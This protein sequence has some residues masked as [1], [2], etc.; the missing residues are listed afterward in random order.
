MQY[1]SPEVKD[2][3]NLVALTAEA[4]GMAHLGF[5]T[6]AAVS[7][8]IVPGPGGG[9]T[10][11]TTDTGRTLGDGATADDL[12]G[13]GGGGGGGGDGDTAGESG[14]GTD[15][16]GGG[17]GSGGGGAAGKLPFTGFAAAAVGALGAGLAA[18]GAA[19]RKYLS[20][21]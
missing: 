14:S 9:D 18:A 5:G 21:G 12:G 2:Y 17:E 10:L 3:G 1:T 15:P 7:S 16:S 19:A 20:R 8:P 4:A 6:I 13:G 11:G